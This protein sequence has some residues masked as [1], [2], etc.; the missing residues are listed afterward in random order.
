MI[1][2][3]GSKLKINSSRFYLEK[4]A[5]QVAETTHEGAMVLDAG[6]GSCPYKEFF[7]H[8]KYE[9]AD[10]CSVDKEY[11][12]ITYV[13]DLSK[14]PVEDDYYDLVFCSQTLEHVPEPKEVLKEFNRILKC[15]GK[16]YLSAPLFFAEHEIPYDFYRY[17]Q[18]GL[19]H[20]LNSSGFQVVQID[21]LEGYYG[22]LSY[23]IEVAGRS[24]PLNPKHY[25][26]GMNGFLFSC[27]VLFLKPIFIILS[28]M[29]SRLDIRLKFTDA[30]QCKN[31][32]VLATK[33]KHSI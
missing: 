12:D 9:S 28:F 2:E 27:L 8:T 30:G 16:L 4:F 14:I 19:T 23:Q 11:A 32:T 31:Y 18:Y 1:K 24:L 17:T 26:G 29:F 13:C 21:W 33:P 7:K 5:R 10:F 20:L 22:T 25:G 3:I 15:G 6:A